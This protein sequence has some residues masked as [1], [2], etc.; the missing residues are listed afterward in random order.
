MRTTFCEICLFDDASQKH[1]TSFILNGEEWG[2][3]QTER[4]GERERTDKE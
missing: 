1:N 3:G 4:E 2:V